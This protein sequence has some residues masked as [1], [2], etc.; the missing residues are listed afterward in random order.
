MI[1]KVVINMK[2]IM[3]YWKTMLKRV[4]VLGLAAMLLTNSFP[5]SASAQS[6]QDPLLQSTEGTNVSYIGSDGVSYTCES[7]TVLADGSTA[8]TGWYVAEG[9]LTIESRVN[10]T[11]DAHLILAD[12]A[13]LTIPRGIN[14]GIGKS[15]TIYAQSTGSSMG[16]LTI[17]GVEFGNAGIGGDVWGNC[18]SVT[19][20]GGIVTVRG[21]THGAGIGSGG[22]VGGIAGGEYE[23]ITINGGMITATSD[24]GAGIGAGHGGYGKS[25]TIN[26][27]TVTATSSTGAGIG[28]GAD[29][30]LKGTISIYGGTVT[31]TSSTGA[32]IGDATTDY[33][34]SG[35]IILCLPNDGSSVWAS[36]YHCKELIIPEGH[37]VKLKDDTTHTFYV[38][39][40]TKEEIDFADKTFVFCPYPLA[41]TNVE[42]TT[43]VKASHELALEGMQVT[44]TMDKGY[45]GTPAVSYTVD[46]QTHQ[47]DMT[48]VNDTTYTFNMPAYPVT[49][50]SVWSYDIDDVF[51]TDEN[52][53]YTV[54]EGGAT[55]DGIT[56]TRDTTIVLTEG[57]TLTVNGIE[58]Q[59][60]YRDAISGDNYDLTIRGTGKLVLTGADN[61]FVGS[62]GTNCKNVT[63]E[64]GIIE[65][66]SPLGMVAKE[67]L[68]VSGG[69]I[70]GMVGGILYSITGRTIVTG[71]EING[72]VHGI[73]EDGITIS[74]GQ[75][76]A[77]AIINLDFRED[78]YYPITLGCSSA[79][80]FIYAEWYAGSTITIAEGQTLCD[81]AGNTYSGELTE[82]QIE[83]ITEKKLRRA[84][85]IDIDANIE[86]GTVTADRAFVAANADDKTVTLTITPV[87]GYVLDS[88]SVKQGYNDVE[89]TRGTGENA[90][91]YTFT[92]PAGDVTVTATFA[93]S[94]IET[95]PKDLN[96]VYGYAED[97]VLTVTTSCTEGYSHSY[98]WYFSTSANGEDSTAIDGATS[99][100]YTI[101]AG[102]SVGT[103]YYYCVVTDTHEGT[104]ETVI[105]VSDLATVT[106]TKADYS[107]IVSISDLTKYVPGDKAEECTITL[108]ELP[109][110]AKYY[111]TKTDESGMIHTLPT[112]SDSNEL[113][114][115]TS[116]GI[117]E[118]ATAEITVEVKDATNYN[119]Y[120]FKVNV[121]AS[122]YTVEY[123]WPMQ[124]NEYLHEDNELRWS[125]EGITLDMSLLTIKKNGSTVN[126]IDYTAKLGETLLESGENHVV[127]EPGAYHIQITYDNGKLDDWV[128][129][130]VIKL[131]EDETVFS[132]DVDDCTWRLEGDA[133][134]APAELTP[135]N[136]HAVIRCNGKE[137]ELSKEV[138]LE[139]FLRENE[140]LELWFEN[141]EI[142][143]FDANRIRQ[144][145]TID[146]PEKVE[147]YNLE[148]V[149]T[150]SM[151]QYS[152]GDFGYLG[153]AG[154]YDLP[155]YIPKGGEFKPLL[156]DD[157]EPVPASS[158]GGYIYYQCGERPDLHYV[159]TRD[160]NGTI[161]GWQLYNGN[162]IVPENC[163]LLDGNDVYYGNGNPYVTYKNVND[164]ESNFVSCYPMYIMLDAN[165]KRWSD[166][167]FKFLDPDDGINFYQV[168]DKHVPRHI[169]PGSL[170]FNGVPLE[171]MAFDGSK[172]ILL[173]KDFVSWQ[174]GIYYTGDITPV[175]VD[176]NKIQ[177]GDFTRSAKWTPIFRMPDFS[178]SD[179]FKEPVDTYACG[180]AKYKVGEYSYQVAK[181]YF[182]F[183]PNN[184][185]I[186]IRDGKEEY[187]V[188]EDINLRV[189]FLGPH[190][191]DMYV[192]LNGQ[193]YDRL[194]YDSK[195]NRE[196]VVTIQGLQEGDYVID[197]KGY[198]DAYVTGYE[199]TLAFKVVRSEPEVALVGNTY[200]GTM[201]TSGDRVEYDPEHPISI[202]AV[203]VNDVNGA[204][205]SDISWTWTISDPKVIQQDHIEENSRPD[206]VASERIYLNTLGLGEVTVTVK[207]S[208]DAIYYPSETET[209]S[210]TVVPMEVPHPIIELVGAD[211]IYYDGTAKEPQVKVYYEKGKLIPADQYEVSYENNIYATS[212][213]DKAKVTVKRKDDALYDFNNLEAEFEI[214]GSVTVADG[215]EHGTVVISDGRT[216]FAKG[217]TV[218]L[219]ITPDTSYAL[220]TLYY[221]DGS[222][223]AITLN[224]DG[225]SF[226]MPAASV[227]VTAVFLLDFNYGMNI[228]LNGEMNV[229][230]DYPSFRYTGD[231]IT[232]EVRVEDYVNNVEALVQDTDYTVSYAN[233]IGSEEKITEATVTITGIGNYTGTKTSIFRIV[234][235]SVNVANCEIKGK[236]EAYYN[237]DQYRA[238]PVEGIEVWHG[239]TRLVEGEDYDIEVEWKATYEVN[240]TYTATI[241]G[242]GDW[243]GEKT[244][245]VTFVELYH[246]VV[247][248]ANG[249]TGTM[250]DDIVT[251]T[252]S[253]GQYTYTLPE[254]AFTAPDG[255]E[256]DHW[257]VSCESGIKKPGDYF[258]APPIWNESFVQTIT[259][260]AEWRER[261]TVTLSATAEAGNITISPSG[262]L[263]EGDTVTLKAKAVPGYHFDGWYEGDAKVCDTLVYSF[264]INADRTLVAKYT[265]RG[266]AQVDIATRN[267][268]QYTIDGSSTPQAGGT[269]IVPLG[270][271]LTLTAVDD[272]RFLQ[273]QNES[274]KILG[275]GKTLSIV[276]TEDMNITLVYKASASDGNAFVQFVS[277]YGQVFA[278]KIYG[279]N[280]PITFPIAP[281][282]F[283]YTFVKW[284]FEGT[285]TTATE[286]AILD[287]IGKEGTITVKPYYTKDAE[288]FT[289]TVQYEGVTR[290]DD[291]YD[292]KSIGTGFTVK[293]PA[294][295]GYV[296]QHWKR[297][298][299]VIGYSS[300]Y[301]MQIAE[302]VTLIAVY[303]SESVEAEPVISVTELKAETVENIDKV[304][305]ISTRNIPAD[306]TVLEHGMLYGK[307]LG[308]LTA[309]SFIIGAEGV[310]SYKSSDLSNNGVFNMTVRVSSKDLVVY[311]RAYMKLVDNRTGNEVICYSGIRHGSYSQITQQ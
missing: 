238:V 308:K 189:E 285:Q 248:D 81:E 76:N 77:S 242:K 154:D 25:I 168:D 306:Y 239:N 50:S 234:P 21:G 253:F 192:F 199:T 162:E 196:H 138:D 169:A 78:K 164:D 226:E 280:D 48:K 31:A 58:T 276:V 87:E 166:Y 298:G 104:G 15:L 303:G 183:L 250:A 165:P 281:T 116:S 200:D 57:N 107:E 55:F 213:D 222:D 282:K 270:T 284:V 45:T 209:I 94:N 224:E 90:N 152:I 67:C 28:A 6:G 134:A 191:G 14:V 243:G 167:Q 158:E 88:L 46:D 173:G 43:H 80:D 130:K 237:V 120:S 123:A 232:P 161:T 110:G 205:V 266:L 160:Q 114:F 42:A 102:K 108:P 111:F 30:H 220:D 233:N 258:T 246:T 139:D 147:F 79:E 41:V 244:F 170:V 16:M 274:G 5:V 148:N 143:K 112:E 310:K 228:Y 208:G 75:I 124:E 197:F 44:L 72:S 225:Y 179:L 37:A 71:G 101:P 212:A 182:N 155:V 296:F 277:D 49:I 304:I 217:E 91:Q 267:F 100:S 260:T 275:R 18:G 176:G 51:T 218:H 288:A 264:T 216:S 74:G 9:S 96:L 85:T 241:T 99:A 29:A 69:K 142:G 236:L 171:H 268:A 93:H 180:Y 278:A 7:C 32:G 135:P 97:H 210:F 299:E 262:T 157:G 26:G 61:G 181:C 301:F 63:I 289:V 113:I 190:K 8:W 184:S 269:E 178:V 156:D 271:T 149:L 186:T 203:I 202:D 60:G 272:E 141:E 305:G 219:T 279:T 174:Y 204:K 39:T 64:D 136:K 19:I 65:D 255:Y 122:E 52:G 119:D 252:D 231:P 256:F 251:K 163:Y 187:K 117:A 17:Q 3:N 175:V 62:Y 86:N 34:F 145:I 129:F 235:D 311:F 177:I 95:Q 20:N 127:L 11:G 151:F 92:M 198:T 22:E 265:A 287:K 54:P 84:Y 13:S 195:E 193:L 27:G 259:V 201:F 185:L 221:N 33:Y 56:L 300:S 261:Q 10:V 146:E 290:D 240:Q 105:G 35:K 206:E 125:K 133:S 83:D 257:E 128:E 153:R 150:L 115:T 309:D 291:V 82:K 12:G 294:I 302:D 194:D 273:W 247:F 215:I 307:D 227:T 53:V 229:G 106:V 137:I 263:R 47:V 36:T 24:S 223:H 70:N 126:G 98:Q 121:F 68:T 103:S 295:D 140:G 283:G 245:G 144:L 214:Q 23:S 40:L 4:A 66:K 118:N 230:H 38:N 159:E 172:Y 1:K 254:C 207:S 89:T 188:G 211:E 297:G 73:S 292:D 131:I 249:G 293:A 286:A 2:Q 59:D 132:L 109:D